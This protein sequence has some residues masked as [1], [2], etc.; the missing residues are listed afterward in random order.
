[1]AVLGS[2]RCPPIGIAFRICATYLRQQLWCGACALL[3]KY[4]GPRASTEAPL[5]AF[6][7]ERDLD[8]ANGQFWIEAYQLIVGTGK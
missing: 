2:V 3:L 1:V 6:F 4:L 7:A 8:R 5:H